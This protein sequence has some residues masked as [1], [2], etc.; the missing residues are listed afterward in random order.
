MNRRHVIASL[1][2]L[3]FWV[4]G[5]ETLRHEREPKLDE[6]GADSAESAA[7]GVRS[8]PPKGFFKGTRLP[9]ALSDEAREI[10]NNLGVQ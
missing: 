4:C 10:E 1:V 8:K 2:S 3:A 9:G 5:C 6:V 7:V